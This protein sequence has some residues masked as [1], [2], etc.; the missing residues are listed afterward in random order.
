MR[1]YQ[2]KEREGESERVCEKKRSKVKVN[3]KLH[4]AMNE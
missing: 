1:S 4:V 3:G 2:V